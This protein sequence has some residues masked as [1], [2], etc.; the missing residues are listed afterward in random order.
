[1]E[2]LAF[3]L[4]F[5][6]CL[7][8]VLTWARPQPALTGAAAIRE[9]LDALERAL[10]A[11]RTA[12]ENLADECEE[13]LQAAEK[14]RRRAAQHDRRVNGSVEAEVAPGGEQELPPDQQR[15]LI[16]AEMRARRG[17]V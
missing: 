4:A 10:P 14:K 9:R 8:A 11:W 15:A 16:L 7:V 6:A 3:G 2:F 5:V 13:T 12:M 17:R 1:M